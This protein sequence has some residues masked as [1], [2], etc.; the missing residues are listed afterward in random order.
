MVGAL[1]IKTI[2]YY[3]KISIDLIFSYNIVL[4]LYFLLIFSQSFFFCYRVDFLYVFEAHMYDMKKVPLL[5]PE[6]F[7]LSM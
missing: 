4:Y 6:E 7:L 3:K 2:I 5:L 1:S